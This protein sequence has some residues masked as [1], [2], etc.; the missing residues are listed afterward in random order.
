M[1]AP[2]TPVRRDARSSSC[3]VLGVGDR[4]RRRELFHH[5]PA[6]TRRSA[7]SRRRWSRC[8]WSRI[9]CPASRC[10]CCSAG[11]SRMRRAARSPVGG[12][13]RLHVRLVALFSIIAAVPTLLVAI[14]ASL[15]FQYGVAVLVFRR[16]RGDARECRPRWRSAYVTSSSAALAAKRP[17]TMASD[18]SR[19]ICASARSS[20]RFRRA[21]SLQQVYYRSLSEAA[22]VQLSP[23]RRASRRWRSSIPYERRLDAPV[24]PATIARAARRARPRSSTRDRRPHRGGHDRCPDPT[25][26]YLYAAPRR[27]DPKSL[28]QQTS[29]RERGAGDYRSLL[30]RSRALQ[31]QFNAALLLDLAADRRHRGVDRAGG[32]RPAGA[33]GRRAGRRGAAGRRRR[34]DRAR[35]A[36]AASATRS[37][38]WP[39]PSTG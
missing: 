3:V 33:A 36:T 35:A 30:A 20:P 29:A 23:Q 37:A 10:S 39:T 24:T 8:C 1:T 6:A 26:C 19:A 38:R 5:Q 2:A 13:G 18:M 9:W 28:S 11:A 32:R 31:L 21:A 12:G 16:A 27:R 15:L 4:D 25:S 14:F 34:S 17:S 7:C 22:I